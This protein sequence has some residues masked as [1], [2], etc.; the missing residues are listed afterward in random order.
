MT[1]IELQQLADVYWNQ[2][3]VEGPDQI[4]NAYQAGARMMLGLVY[5]ELD[6]CITLDC[7]SAAPLLDDAFKELLP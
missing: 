3:D 4:I 1:A 6:Q 5:K 7:E 2:E